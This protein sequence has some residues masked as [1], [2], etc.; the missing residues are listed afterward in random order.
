MIESLQ[1]REQFT[2][3]GQEQ[4]FRYWDVLDDEQRAILVAQASEIDLAGL[5]NQTTQLLSKCVT[6]PVTEH[7]LKPPP[8]I[9]HPENGG[10]LGDWNEARKI[11][12]QALNTGKVAALIV[13]GGQGTRLGF[14]G[15]KGTFPVTPVTR[16]T[17][18][19]VFADKIK[20]ASRIYN[21]SINWLIMTSPGNHDATLKY[22]E[23]EN[24]FGLPA[25]KVCFF[26]QGQMPAVD[27]DGKILLESKSAIALSPDGHGGSLEAFVKSGYCKKMKEQGIELISYF[28]VDNPLLQC[29][30]PVFIG[31]HL[32][33]ESEL[34]SK[35]VLKQSAE[36]KTGVFCL[37]NDRPG[38]IEYS[39][40]P[41]DLQEAIHDDGRLLYGAGNIA[42]HLF[43]L[44]FIERLVQPDKPFALPFHRADKK[45]PM[46]DDNGQDYIPKE[47]NGIKFERFVFDAI[48]LAHNPIIVEALRKE[49]FSPVK[50]AEGQDSAQTCR[51]D[52]L[53][54]WASWLKRAGVSV[55]T[56]KTGLPEITFEISADFADDQETFIKN[57]HQL[58][59]KPQI[60][61]G[62]VLEP[63]LSN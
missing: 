52:Q 38:V 61:E 49:A 16:K 26:L 51:D 17:L 56:D 43:S 12:E 28:Q 1:L 20:G 21:Q 50:N 27:Y 31:F 34:S 59:E 22:F 13:A 32:Q 19:N 45:I 39:D 2:Q 41:S 37:Q 63:K 48:P 6:L 25:D 36:E 58:K 46:L 18:F 23:V 57:W 11:G 33:H 42:A 55:K 44:D 47:P 35:M 7:S 9:Q 29:I 40:M 3:A 8:Y 10:H 4:V 62:L 5:T 14:E 54:R 15:P 53:R 30:D 60:T 24:Y